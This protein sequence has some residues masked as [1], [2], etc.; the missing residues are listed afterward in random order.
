MKDL[1]LK[2]YMDD[3]NKK[4]DFSELKEDDLFERFVNFN[5]V[6]KLY[7]RDIDIEE[8]SVGGKSDTGIDGIAIIVNGSIIKEKEEIDFFIKSNG[9]IYVK[10]IFIQSKNSSHFE[11]SKINKFI[12]GVSNFF[13]YNSFLLENETI[14]RLREIKNKIYD[15]SLSFHIKPELKLYFVTTGKWI[16]DSDIVNGAE[17]NL[18]DLR[19]KNIFANEDIIEYVDL[20]R[21]KKYYQENNRKITKELLFN[22]RV[23]LPELSAGVNQSFIGTISA[24]DYIELISDSDG[25]ISKGLFFDNVRDYQG[26]NKVNQEICN[27]LIDPN[28]R[29]LLPLL[30]NGITI[31]AKKLDMVGQKVKLSDFQIVN[32]C[33]SSYVLF[34]NREKLDENIY[35]VVK[36]IETLNQDVIDNIIRATNRQTEVKDEAFESLK[37]FHK[38]LVEYYKAINGKVS[39]KIFYER[40]SKEYLNNPDISPYQVITLS[41]QIKSYVAMVLEQPQSTHRYFGELLE[42]NR[43][44]IFNL[45]KGML[46][47]YYISAFLLNRLELMFRNKDIYLKYKNYKFHMIY[48]TYI[49]LKNRKLQEL[50]MI[51][52]IDNYQYIKDVFVLTC[53]IIKQ[54]KLEK[55]LNIDKQNIRN[56]DFSVY[57]KKNLDLFKID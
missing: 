51:E 11:L 8:L 7:P 37:P 36:I 26:N 46:P 15:N 55:K 27:T 42:S 41:A 13:E 14:V 2:S 49:I 3:F 10:F 52:M 5:I 4:H 31:I 16:G 33:Q 1:I 47:L 17:F 21:L 19:N 56:R 43:E 24:K 6:S 30:N 28:N 39:S 25:N 29:I 48:L 23:A 44:K 50:K 57:L 54:T 22:N 45:D 12:L 20:E 53:K 18:K 32:G 38:E 40:R 9:S 34:M 35:I